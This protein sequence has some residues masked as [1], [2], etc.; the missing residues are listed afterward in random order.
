M[1]FDIENIKN[2]PATQ[3]KFNQALD[4]F[5]ENLGD[6]QFSISDFFRN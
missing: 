3:I 4:T 1:S 2:D 5:Y 6:I